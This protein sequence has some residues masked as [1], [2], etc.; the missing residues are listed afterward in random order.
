M[1]VALSCF[2]G[3]KVKLTTVLY[4]KSREIRNEQFIFE[5]TI[6]NAVIVQRTRFLEKLGDLPTLSCIECPLLPCQQ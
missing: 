5:L 6:F 3:Q 4:D 2:I 1:V